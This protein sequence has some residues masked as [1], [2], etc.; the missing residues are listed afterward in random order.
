MRAGWVR[1]AS[2]AGLVALLLMPVLAS[3]QTPGIFPP[4]AERDVFAARP[5][6]YAPRFDRKL[7]P[8]EMGL[9]FPQPTV[10]WPAI[11]AAAPPPP[12]VVIV[13][14]PP[15]SPGPATAPAL[16]PP[17]VAPA[18]PPAAAPAPGPRKP[19]YVIPLCYA[20]DKPPRPDQLR[21]GC[22]LADLRTISPNQ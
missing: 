11:F 16:V 14:L 3:A 18:V 8:A 4:P 5:G 19:L 10:V 13:V 12:P 22:R 1:G 21:P 20:G 2:K 15:S 17:A 7:T 6:T 9:W